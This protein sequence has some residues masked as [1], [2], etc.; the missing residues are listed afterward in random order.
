MSPK[1]AEVWEALKLRHWWREAHGCLYISASSAV[2][3]LSPDGV[4]I[5]TPWEMTDFSGWSI[6]AKIETIWLQER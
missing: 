2:H 4:V 5:Q 6:T 3:R 1:V